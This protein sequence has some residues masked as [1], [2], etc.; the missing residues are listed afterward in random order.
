MISNDVIEFY[1]IKSP[2][3][4]QYDIKNTLTKPRT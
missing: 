1:I 3:P 4:G 2:G